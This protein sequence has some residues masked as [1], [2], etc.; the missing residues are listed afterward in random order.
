[1]KS[2]LGPSFIF[3]FYDN[4]NLLDISVGIILKIDWDN[5]RADSKQK[6]VLYTWKELPDCSRRI[7]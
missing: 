1:M 5:S 4:G 6:C 3:N 7:W 2:E